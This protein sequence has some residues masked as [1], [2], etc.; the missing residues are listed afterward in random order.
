MTHFQQAQF[1]K[2]VKDYFFKNSLLSILEI[3]SYNVNG[4][5]RNIFTNS[6]EY[7]GLDIISGPDVDIVYDGK[8][9]DLK[10][11]FDLVVSCECF[12]HNPYY[13][14]NFLTMIQATKDDGVIL[15]TCATVGRPEHGTNESELDFS[16]SPGSMNKWNYYKNLTT[17]DFVKKIDLNNLFYKYQFYINS[18]SRDLYFLG[19]KNKKY[20]DNFNKLN[21]DIY[22]LNSN[23]VIVNEKLSNVI[24]KKI[25]FIFSNIL[26][27]LIGDILTR[28]LRIFLK[29]II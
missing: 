14:E 3:G 22:Y 7:V 12:E 2:L 1:C 11:K 6:T 10:K 13:I 21:N 17:K 26:P 8:N 24:E 25:R 27:Y 4:S 9:I 5:L 15:F 29:K 20:L 28:K 18:F 19:I 16:S 23:T